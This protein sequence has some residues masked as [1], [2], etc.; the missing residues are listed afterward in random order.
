[1]SKSTRTRGSCA[2]KAVLA[3]ATE[4]SVVKRMAGTGAEGAPLVRPEYKVGAK[5]FS[6]GEAVGT[7]SATYM[8]RNSSQREIVSG[9]SESVCVPFIMVT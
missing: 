4:G 9:P 6:V 8:S 5:A 2:A 1:M 3:A 7:R